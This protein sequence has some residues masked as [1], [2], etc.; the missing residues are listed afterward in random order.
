MPLY[1]PGLRG[2][3]LC[4]D[5]D[6]RQSRFQVGERV[7]VGGGLG[8]EGGEKG[9]G[10][11][12]GDEDGDGGEDEGEMRVLDVRYWC[13][14]FYYRVGRVKGNGNK[15]KQEE[16]GDLLLNEEELVRMVE[17]RKRQ[18]GTALTSK[19]GGNE[20]YDGNVT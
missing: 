4:R 14:E 7:S 12:D 10:V 13:G 18:D 5:A 3:F 11:R 6:L 16:E 17:G 15:E 8:V 20:P 1:N 19:S 2:L 9:Q